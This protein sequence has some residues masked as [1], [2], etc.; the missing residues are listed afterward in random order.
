[1]NTVKSVRIGPGT[2]FRS[3]IADS[4]PEWEI[5]RSRGRG[6]WEAKVVES[7]SDHAGRVKV[8]T[9]ADVKHAVGMAQ[10]FGRI[11]SEH[12]KFYAGLT[13]GQIVHYENTMGQ[14][15][16]CEVVMGNSRHDE[17]KTP[18]KVL[19]AVALVG[20]WSH[21]LPRRMLDGTINYGSYSGMVIKGECM[22]P[23]Y[24]NIYETG[25]R[26]A[27]P[28]NLVAIDLSVSEMTADE[29]A[30][31]KLWLAVKAAK[32]ALEGQDN[33]RSPNPRARLTEALAAIQAAL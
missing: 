6:V 5:T 25:R 28:R 9:H 14:W 27:D 16:R 12:D 20:S 24:T 26:G 23:N 7:D 22:E 19:K 4:N 17:K 8:F 21:D 13:V 10:V 18:H 1:M 32:S 29:A 3:I 33:D 2:K 15:V 30:T 11:M 31:A